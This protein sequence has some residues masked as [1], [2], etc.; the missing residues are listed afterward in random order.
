MPGSPIGG[1]PPPRV[2]GATGTHGWDEGGLFKILFFKS[3]DY[4]SRS[5][6]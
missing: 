3:R 5:N 1:K 6:N 4:K 2:E